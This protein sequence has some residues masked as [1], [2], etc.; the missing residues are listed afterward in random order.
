M[1]KQERVGK[2]KKF[3]PQRCA[4]LQKKQMRTNEVKRRSVK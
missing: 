3:M 4:R 1:S 2:E